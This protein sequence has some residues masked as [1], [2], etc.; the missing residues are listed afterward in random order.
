MTNEEKEKFMG[1][2]IKE[3]QKAFKR[4]EV[5]IGAV[6]VKNGKIIAKAHNTREKTKNA[7]SHAE[8]L[9]VNNACKKLRNWRLV[10]CDIFVTLEPCIMCLGALYNARIRKLYYGASNKS[11]G[12]IK[13]DYSSV[14]Q[15][16]KL[17]VENGIKESEVKE[18]LAGFFR[19]RNS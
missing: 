12:D 16:H 11:N 6:I 1:E 19:S 15:N 2:A 17:E 3:A 4:R 8:I 7:L 18:L 9:A 5:P 14:I 10:D 13:I